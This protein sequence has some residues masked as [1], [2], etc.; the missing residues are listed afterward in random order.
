VDVGSIHTYLVVRFVIFTASVRNI[1]VTPLH[2]CSMSVCVGAGRYSIPVPSPSKPSPE[3]AC[4]GKGITKG[5]S[6]TKQRTLGGGGPLPGLLRFDPVKGYRLRALEAQ[7]VTPTIGTRPYGVK[8]VVPS[9]VTH[10]LAPPKR[11]SEE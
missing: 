4:G 6:L 10:H 2:V 7:T 5:P 8:T 11:G 9:R 1:L 3:I